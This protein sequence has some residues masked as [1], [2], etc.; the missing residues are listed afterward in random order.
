MSDLKKKTMDLLSGSDFS[1]SFAD[2]GRAPEGCHA[3]L[4]TFAVLA[5][6][7]YEGRRQAG[8]EA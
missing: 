5:M 4:T 7:F 2:S 6:T 1:T 8:V 3:P